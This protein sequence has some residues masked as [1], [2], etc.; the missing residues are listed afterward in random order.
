M[1][2]T[3]LET[4]QSERGELSR[5]C[6]VSLILGC[7]ALLVVIA[8]VVAIVFFR[9]ELVQISSRVLLTD[10]ESHIIDAK[11]L[12]FTEEDIHRV[13]RYASDAIDSGRISDVE[14]V[15]LAEEKKSIMSDSL[16]NPEK[17]RR[18]LEILIRATDAD[19]ALNLSVE[20]QGDTNA[21]GQRDSIFGAD[22]AFRK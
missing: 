7:V 20:I 8:F 21:V 1:R 5:G 6:L 14:A 4:L 18:F 9:D 22:S 10:M 16:P 15:Q 19:S 2:R 3:A 12:G 17:A 11:P 13:F